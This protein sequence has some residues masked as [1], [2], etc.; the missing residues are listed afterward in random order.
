MGRRLTQ[1]ARIGIVALRAEQQLVLSA[2]IQEIS[3]PLT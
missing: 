1:I 2:F 3:V